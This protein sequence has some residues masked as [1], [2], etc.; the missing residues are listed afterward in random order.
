MFPN[1]NS[2]FSY[3]ALIAAANTSQFSQFAN[4]GTA[5]QRKQ[6]V[7]AFFANIGHETT[8]GWATAPGGKHAWGLYWK[9]EVGC[10]SGTCTGYCINYGNWPCAPG[11]TYHGRGPIQ[12]SYNFNYG[13]AGQAIGID[14]LS[15]PELVASDGV[16]SFKTA[17]WFW[18]TPQAPK[19]SCHDVMTG[20]WQPSAQ[21]LAAGRKPGLG[22]TINIINGGLE[23]TRP[24][25][26]RVEDRVGFYQ[27][28]TGMLSVPTGE[29][30]YCDQMQHY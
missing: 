26:G 25:D 4:K 13:P 15:R 21:D 22:M 16:V 28:F 5:T 8:G 17:L 7:A 2:L 11:K 3:D 14:L 18:M 27:R 10:E 1:R 23:C 19:P 20:G 24:T 9:E 29:N 6:E 12:L 30:M